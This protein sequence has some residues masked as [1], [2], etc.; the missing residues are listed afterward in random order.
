MN[1]ILFKP[2]ESYLP[3]SD[4]RSEH[5][6]NILH[7][8]VGDEFKYGIYN[9]EEGKAKIEKIDKEG[10]Y[11]SFIKEREPISLFPL[12]LLIAQVRPICMKRIIRD[13]V[14]LGVEKIIL[15]VSDLGEKSYLKASFYTEEEYKDVIIDGAMQASSA[16]IPLSF[17]TS[18]LES[19]LSLIGEGKRILLDNVI[20]ENPLSKMEIKNQRVILAIGP[21]R[22]WSD[23]ERNLLLDNNF[24]PCLLGKRV[25]R[26]ETAVTAATS[27]ALST[28]NLI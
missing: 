5:I 8:N 27:I 23:R 6:I 24:E 10:I 16:S 14:S 21:E 17:I 28:M 26:T 18:S 19:S 20:G 7:L 22:G 13:A 12:T 2:E 3:L 1:I 25:L 4:R 9:K 11:L 15:C